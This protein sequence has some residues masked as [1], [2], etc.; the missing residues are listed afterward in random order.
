[1]SIQDRKLENKKKKNKKPTKIGIIFFTKLKIESF[2]K[3][4]MKFSIPF[5]KN[6]TLNTFAMKIEKFKRLNGFLWINWNVKLKR[7][8]LN[9]KTFEQRRRSICFLFDFGTLGNIGSMN[10]KFLK[11]QIERC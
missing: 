2:L 4:E 10:L 7:E 9:V 3:I 5:K 8:K 11:R 6:A 1:M